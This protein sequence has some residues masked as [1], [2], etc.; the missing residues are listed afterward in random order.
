MI[1]TEGGS[2]TEGRIYF[3]ERSTYPEAAPNH[4]KDNHG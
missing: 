1:F 4:R 3:N 2:T